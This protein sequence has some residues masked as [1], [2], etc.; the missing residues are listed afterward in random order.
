MHGFVSGCSDNIYWEHTGCWLA[1]NYEKYICVGCSKLAQ[2]YLLFLQITTKHIF[3][4]LTQKCYN[5][6][7]CIAFRIALLLRPLLVLAYSQCF[8]HNQS[9]RYHMGLGIS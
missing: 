9:T 7:I 6:Y 5:G 1:N 4:C 8:G 3:D 2:V